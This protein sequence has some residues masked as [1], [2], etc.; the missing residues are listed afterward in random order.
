MKVMT[1]VGTRP[2]IIRLAETIKVLD[3][4]FEHVLVHTGQNYDYEL[5]QVFFDNLKLREPDYFLAAARES[6][7]ATVSAILAEM[8]NVLATERPDAFLVLGDTNSAL[9]AYVAKRRHIP[10]FHVEA[11]NRS[12]DFRVPEEINRRIVDHISDINLTYSEHAR[13]YLIAEGFPA[14]RVIKVGSPMAEVINKNIHAIAE[15]KILSELAVAEG[16]YILV[17]A[18]REENVDLVDR[19]TS[20][21]ACLEALVESMDVEV[22]VSLHPRTAKRIDTCGLTLGPRIRALKPFGFIDYLALQKHAACVVSDSGTVTEEASIIGFPA[23]TIR[24]AHERPEG[25]DE[26]VLIMADL[27]P[28][29]VV[30]A[31][32]LAIAQNKT[33]GP[34]KLVA[35]YDVN[36]VS[37]KIAKIIA[38][39]TDFVKREVWK[40]GV[41]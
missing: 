18:H 8:D 26:G 17:S 16:R 33:Y 24:Q 2:E 6:P 19:L 25:M 3:A 29:R 40:E 37:W 39:Y 9:S 12:F 23:V 22:I 14:D 27:N 32:S 21:V 7:I 20:L 30:Q 10:I 1:V 5:N 38:S 31:V 4:N 15:S 28:S 41:V 34:S 35:D 11:G 13:R 36:Q